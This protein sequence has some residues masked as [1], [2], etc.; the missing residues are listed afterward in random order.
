MLDPGASETST[1]RSG[2]YSASALME[3][4]NGRCSSTVGPMRNLF[5]SENDWTLTP[6]LAGKVTFANGSV[7]GTPTLMPAEK[8]CPKAA[9]MRRKK[10]TRRIYSHYDSVA[11]RTDRLWYCATSRYTELMS[12]MLDEIR[13]QPAALERTLRGGF[14]AAS[15][16][17][18]V[19]A[20]RP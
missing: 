2:R 17:A 14:R 18:R 9:G 5:A 10:G 8:S 11:G 4:P 12:K 20:A 16:L 1:R 19:V 7:I 6:P 15:R 3:N 13:E